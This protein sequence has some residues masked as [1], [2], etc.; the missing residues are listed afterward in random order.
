MMCG[1][2]SKI[3]PFACTQ[4]L[5]TSLLTLT[6]YLAAKRGFLFWRRSAHL[7]LGC[8]GAFEPSGD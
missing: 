3:L 5:I 2:T 4:F 1:S 7:V 6:P 8:I